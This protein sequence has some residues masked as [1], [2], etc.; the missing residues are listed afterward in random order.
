MATPTPHGGGHLSHTLPPTT[1]PIFNSLA[2]ATKTWSL[3]SYPI[4]LSKCRALALQRRLPHRPPRVH[5][6]YR[7]ATHGVLP[8]RSPRAGHPAKL[9]VERLACQV[10]NQIYHRC[11]PLLLDL[12][13]VPRKKM[14]MFLSHLLS[15]VLRIV[16]RVL[17]PSTL[18][19]VAISSISKTSSVQHLSFPVNHQHVPPRAVES[20]IPRVVQN[21]SPERARLFR[22]NMVHVS[23]W[24]LERVRRPL[25]ALRING[26]EPKRSYTPSR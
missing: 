2:I 8:R 4:H 5:L 19:T 14:A 22:R 1:I 12:L 10:L 18:L 21:Q 6:L 17:H 26:I 7:R 23:V 11:Y 15:Q 9:R 20:P 16:P 25:C 3:W 24:L 13:K